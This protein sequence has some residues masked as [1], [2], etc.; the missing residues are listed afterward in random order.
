MNKI[1]LM[2][3]VQHLVGLEAKVLSREV[4]IVDNQDNEQ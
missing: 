2:K 3:L 1:D 4:D